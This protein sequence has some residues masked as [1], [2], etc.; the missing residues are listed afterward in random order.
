MAKLL[1]EHIARTAKIKLDGGKLKKMLFEEYM[2]DTESF[3]AYLDEL[4]GGT[5]P[6]PGNQHTWM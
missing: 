3:A 5:K 2:D 6:E 1:S 4:A